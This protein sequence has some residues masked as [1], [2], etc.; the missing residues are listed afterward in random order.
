MLQG[1]H[2]LWYAAVA[3]LALMLVAFLCPAGAEEADTTWGAPAPT[4]F[5]EAG[6]FARWSSEFPWG[7]DE[8]QQR[9][10]PFA[11]VDTPLHT[12]EVVDRLHANGARVIAYVSF[13]QM[14]VGVRSESPFWRS[15][16]GVVHP[17]LR[18]IGED[19]QPRFDDPSNPGIVFV[20]PL[21]PGYREAC[22]QATQGLLDMGFDGLFLDCARLWGPGTCAGPKFGKHEHTFPDLTNDQAFQKVLPDLYAM[23]KGDDPSNIIVFNQA[24]ADPAYL[25]YGDGD[26]LESYAYSSASATGPMNDWPTLLGWA[27]GGPW[28]ELV[29][30]G[31][32]AMALSYVG[33]TPKG[34]R[35]EAF[36][37][38]AAAKLSGFAWGDF[39]TI[40][41][42]AVA[43][44]LYTLR[45]G[46]VR[47][48][49]EEH[50]GVWTRTYAGGIVALNP[51]GEEKVLRLGELNPGPA[52]TFLRELYTN[53]RVATY[54]D[55]GAFL[56]PAG[57][58]R[59][60]VRGF[61]S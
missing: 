20:C 24:W 56:I 60:F 22:L 53:R 42:D 19:G 25:R 46:P 4:W 34:T 61:S 29:G 10:K 30:H 21:A 9:L 31:K 45:L 41:Q 57:C 18:R 17:E 1:T 55:G 3:A 44:Q 7:D 48:E 37:C 33:Y 35:E 38:Y 28:Q 12:Q 54:N 59:V 14:P 40:G 8:K 39:F 50:G 32:V 27:Q 5:R 16:N 58:G 13:S 11:L 15:F 43:Q 52:Y 2:G 23:V 36:Y 47:G 26:M 51:T 6:M 49:L